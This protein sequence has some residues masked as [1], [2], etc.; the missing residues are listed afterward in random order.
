MNKFIKYLKSNPSTIKVVCAVASLWVIIP[1]LLLT[2]MGVPI[3]SS[4]PNI[5]LD[6]G[7]TAVVMVILMFV[8]DTYG[9]CSKNKK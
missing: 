3:G 6:V 7:I 9:C 1:T 8:F 2:L 5:I 4:L